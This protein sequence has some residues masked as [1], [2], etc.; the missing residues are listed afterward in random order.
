MP[1]GQNNGT[2][3]ESSYSGRQRTVSKLPVSAPGRAT[4]PGPATNLNIGMDVWNTSHVGT[5]PKGRPNSANVASATVGANGVMSDH[6]WVQ[7]SCI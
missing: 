5:V 1:P 4:I 6:Q 7:V 2:T 3:A